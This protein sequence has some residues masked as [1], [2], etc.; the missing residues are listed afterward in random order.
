MVDK[1]MPQNFTLS[2]KA[3][4][5]ENGYTQEALAEK[6]GITKRAYIS[7]D[8]I[9]YELID[10]YKLVK[11]D[12]AKIVG[13]YDE[14]TDTDEDLRIMKLSKPDIYGDPSNIKFEIG[15]VRADI[16]TTITDMQKKQ[17]VND[18]Y[19]QGATNILNSDL[20]E[21]A[22]PTHPVKFRVRIPADAL[23]VNYM[24]LTYETEKFRGYTKGVAAGGAFI[25]ESV[26]QSESTSAGGA[27]IK[28]SVV[29]SKSTAAGGGAILTSDPVDDWGNWEG[30][31]LP[32]LTGDAIPDGESHKHGVSL[33]KADF[34]H[35]HPINLPSHLHGF[36][37]TIPE[38]NIPNH[39]HGYSVTIPAITIPEHTH[40][41]QY[42]IYEHDSLPAALEIKVD[43][44]VIPHT[45]LQGE[46]I[47]LT[48]YLSKDSDGRI[49]RDRYAIV[50][51]R[52]IDELAQISATIVWGLFIQSRKGSTL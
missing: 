16:G 13:V 51:I 44:N 31:I 3:A 36:S 38:I 2:L 49:T 27:F 47:D 5:V 29:Q 46:N 6:L 48:P 9:D 52:P 50:E 8:C 37:V 26:V 17:L 1:V 11:Y 32:Y 14:D 24:E 30:D 23:N 4:R 20:V 41:Q 25:K 43:G 34:I 42:G 40:A 39:T 45:A 19:S 10:P 35:S 33:E 18:T 12:I 15:S 28:E 7:W 21:N 22:D